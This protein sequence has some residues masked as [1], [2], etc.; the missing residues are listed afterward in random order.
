M[1]GSRL[2]AIA[3]SLGGATTRRTILGGLTALGA[4]TLRLPGAAVARKRKNKQK[5]QP[6]AYGCLD[7]GQKCG[8]NSARCCSGIC[9]GKKPKKGKKDKSTCVA[10][11]KFDC[12][13]GANSCLELVKCGTNGLCVQT[14]GKA[15]FCGRTG[16]CAVCQ[17]DADCEE[18]MGPGAACTV[19]AAGCP[20]TGGTACYSAAV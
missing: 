14:T 10:H 11:N 3:R 20:E 1:D 16:F 19:C 12:P 9:Q 4:T 6:N 13:A 18:M 8:G 7:T 5:P 2:D 15:S 17:R